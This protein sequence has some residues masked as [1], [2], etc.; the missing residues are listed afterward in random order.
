MAEIG[1]LSISVR[2]DTRGFSRRA[3]DNIRKQL[4][5]GENPKVELDPEFN[6]T[7]AKRALKRLKDELEAQPDRVELLVK[8]DLAQALKALKR[9]VRQLNRA[10][11]TS[12][13][14]K[15]K[16][17]TDVDIDKER[18]F[19]ELADLQ[20]LAK[21]APVDIVTKTVTDEGSRVVTRDPE[22]EVN[23][24]VRLYQREATLWGATREA[25]RQASE[26]LWKDVAKSSGEYFERQHKRYIKVIEKY[27]YDRPDPLDG[28]GMTRNWYDRMY[29]AGIRAGD[30]MKAGFASRMGAL[31]ERLAYE[32]LSGRLQSRFRAAGRM[33]ANVFRAGYANTFGRIDWAAVGKVA[34]AQAAVG[35]G[36]GLRRLS[37]MRVSGDFARDVWEP[38]ANFDRH[39]P[40]LIG[41]SSVLTTIAGAVGALAADVFSLALDLSRIVPILLTVPGIFVSAGLAIASIVVGLKGMKDFAPEIG[42]AYQ[43]FGKSM[44]TEFWRAK[45]AIA[46]ALIGIEPELRRGMSVLSGAA[47][48]LVG[49][50]LKDVE[51]IVEPHIGNMFAAAGRGLEIFAEHTAS[52]ARIVRDLGRIGAKYFPELAAWGGKLADSFA[53]WLSKSVTSGKVFAWV[54]TAIDRMKTLG[55]IV[56]DTVGLIGDIGRI[57]ER[58]GGASL[59]SFSKGLKD[60]RKHLEEGSQGAENLEKY[61]RAAKLTFKGFLSTVT[62]G[63][64]KFTTMMAGIAEDVGP[65]LSK[66]LGGT[67][68]ALLEGF[69]SPAFARATKTFAREVLKL[70]GLIKPIVKQSSEL[71]GIFDTIN[72]A[73][74]PFGRL[75]VA[76]VG[77]V[78]TAIDDLG[79]SLVKTVD[80]LGNAAANLGITAFA[81]LTKTISDLGP[82]IEGLSGGI[83]RIVNN[84]L[85]AVGS[86]MGTFDSVVKGLSNTILRALPGIESGLS[87]AV[88]GALKFADGIL[89][90]VDAAIQFAGTGFADTLGAFASIVGGALDVLGSIASAIGDIAKWAANGAKSLGV[91]GDALGHIVGMA[92][93]VAVL[94]RGLG[95]LGGSLTKA[96][97]KMS[98]FASSAATAAGG[99][100]VAVGTQSKKAAKGATAAGDAMKSAG[101]N[102]AVLAGA[103]DGVDKKTG[104]AASSTKKLGGAM[105]STA[106]GAGKMALQLSLLDAGMQVLS[107]KEGPVRSVEEMDEVFRKAALGVGS[108]NDAFKSFDGK[109]INDFLLG[110]VPV[111][112]DMSSAIKVLEDGWLGN[113]DAFDR[114]EVAVR[115]IDTLLTDLTRSGDLETAGEY[116]KLFAQ[117]LEKTGYSAE[118]AQKYM[119]GYADTIRTELLAAGLD[120]YVNDSAK[121]AQILRGELPDGLT[122]TA[123]GY[124]SVEEA[125]KK[126]REAADMRKF[127][128]NVQRGLELIPQTAT[129]SLGQANDEIRAGIND[130]SSILS[131]NMPNIRDYWVQV[132]GGGRDGVKL[133]E[134][135]IGILK[136]AFSEAEAIMRNTGINIESYGGSMGDALEAAFQKGGAQAKGA[137][138]ALKLVG[139]ALKQTGLDAGT[140][141]KVMQE[142]DLSPDTEAA[143]RD[144][145]G[146]LDQMPTHMRKGMGDAVR[147]GNDAAR[148]EWAKMVEAYPHDELKQQVAKTELM[149]IDVADEMGVSIETVKRGLADPVVA[150]GGRGLSKEAIQGL[151]DAGIINEEQRR[152]IEAPVTMSKGFNPTTQ[153]T[154]QWANWRQQESE[155][156]RQV[157]APVTLSKGFNPT[158]QV[159]QQWADFRRQE[160]E[161]RRQIETPI[162][163]LEDPMVNVRQGVWKTSDAVKMQWAPS[164][165]YLDESFRKTGSGAQAMAS[166]VGKAQEKLRPGLPK[167]GVSDSS[168]LGSA[169]KS[170]GAQAAVMAMIVQTKAVAMSSVL[171]TRFTAMASQAT[172]KMGIIQAQVGMQMSMMATSSAR[173]TARMSAAMMGMASA[174]GRASTTLGVAMVGVA[175][176]VGQAAAQIIAASARAGNGMMIMASS[177]TRMAG[178]VQAGMGR[179]VGATRSAAGAIRGSFRG[180]GGWL[181]GAG[182]S[183]MGGLA[184]GIASGIGRIRSMLQSVTAMIPRWK[185]P[186]DTDAKLLVNAGRLIM[187]GLATSM[188]DS[189]ESDVKP[190][191]QRITDEIGSTQMG[192]PSASLSAPNLRGVTDDVAYR[193]GDRG[194]KHINQEINIMY[195]ERESEPRAL[196]RAAQNL[197]VLS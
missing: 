48:K 87:H 159:T 187:G 77:G 1:E 31:N 37:G 172:A 32:L 47:G 114:A 125:A 133:A 146:M 141:E 14:L 66:A 188:W 42:A 11:A 74:V 97:G 154:Q 119:Q 193:T 71:V 120:E 195:P 73:I 98:G 88:S 173:H 5:R 121:F 41:V 24:R 25:M 177:A 51:R 148:A 117:D 101:A 83:A 156:R 99:A 109:P 10:A 106:K 155:A 183:I 174:A 162:K 124:Q 129:R 2:P 33:A 134:K 142:M 22:R 194:G 58:A 189:F 54:E 105:G 13:D 26:R 80:A 113:F 7:A 136:G 190:T 35:F 76:A 147:A 191:L 62:P 128:E 170:V 182:R 132:G 21:E 111:V 168:Q 38:L 53:N 82:L 16:L 100:L 67:I 178:L 45:D 89:K 165:S 118:T 63:L 175:R 110:G 29:A 34:G 196:Q 181:V 17:K 192:T 61:M 90:I 160:S 144:V 140:L 59:A 57:A 123:D 151:L 104:K 180:A 12:E 8:F 18:F 169:F 127:S 115:R 28:L 186:A 197:A 39:L 15:V 122:R 145:L 4:Q 65:K 137:Q 131:H 36:E 103:A 64:S 30:A 126:A 72:A 70:S 96:G 116:Y 91:F 108:L 143:L 52:V 153:V 94:R 179:A 81:P 157:E 107:I 158:T 149:L 184:S 50:F 163:P 3:K 95:T 171:T 85:P 55:S 166:D 164:A 92:V 6:K 60:V 27:A 176:M 84:N 135:N 46:S 150:F 161:A 152:K 23:E 102:A 49:A 185:G 44:Q 68:G 78:L 56:A 112:E 139:E 20:D 130:L 40:K 19:D 93:G 69:A 167:T 79:P 43:G 9:L 75:G 138:D 86:L